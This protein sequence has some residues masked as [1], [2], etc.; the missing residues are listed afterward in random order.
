MQIKNRPKKLQLFGHPEMAGRKEGGFTGN[1]SKKGPRNFR[2]KET[3]R[4][5]F[6]LGPK[7]LKEG[8]FFEIFLAFFC[9]TGH[10]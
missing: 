5:I 3:A 7:T 10:F 6:P 1:R 2:E 9:Y 8:G 4:E